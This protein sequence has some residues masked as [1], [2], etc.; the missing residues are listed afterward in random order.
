MMERTISERGLLTETSSY[1][2]DLS[3][4]AI[5]PPHPD[6]S[7]SHH[8][9]E[10]QQQLRNENGHSPMDHKS[11]PISSI[12]VTP[13][14]HQH[15]QEQQQQY[16]APTHTQYQQQQHHNHQQEQS[17][18]HVSYQQQ[19]NS[20]QNLDPRNMPETGFRAG[21][22]RVRGGSKRLIQRARRGVGGDGGDDGRH[23]DHIKAKLHDKSGADPEGPGIAAFLLTALS[24]LLIIVTMPFSLCLCIKVVTEYERAVIFR[25]GRLRKGGSKGPGIFTVIP[26]IDT[27]KCVDLRTVSFDVPPQEILSRDSVTVSVDAVVYFNVIDAEQALCSIDDFSH[28]TRLLA[29]TTL[30]NVLGTKNLAEILSERETISHIMQSSLDEAT[31][32]WGVKV[33]RVEIKDVRLPVQLQRAMAAEAEAA[34]EARAKVIA[35]EGEQK[36]SKAL[37]EAADVIQESPA[38]LQLRYLQTLNSIAAEHNS[39]IIFPMPMHLA[40]RFFANDGDN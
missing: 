17:H 6:P 24:V 9:P 1:E 15:H 22:S 31:D 35:A 18:H 12:S 3:L 29:A 25:L 11:Q 21:I 5:P 27:Y 30:R 10:G 28:S 40:T 16:M 26:C 33:E 14:H 34:R 2:Q 13:S 32:P 39:T 23:V 8:H 37:K 7:P 36:A 4:R 19:P 38:A 20:P